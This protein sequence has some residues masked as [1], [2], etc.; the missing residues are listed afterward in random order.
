[1]LETVTLYSIFKYGDG[2]G[3]KLPQAFCKKYNLEP[4]DRISIAIGD[5]LIIAPRDKEITSKFWDFVY[6]EFDQ[7]LSIEG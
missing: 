6:N 2:L 3:I 7:K 5:V 1:M 4:K